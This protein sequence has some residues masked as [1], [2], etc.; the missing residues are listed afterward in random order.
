MIEQMI[1]QEIKNLL[2]EGYVMNHENFQFRQ[3]V[4]NT[5]VNLYNYESFSGDYDVN[6]TD[7]NVFVK[8]NIKFWLNE[9]GVENFIVEV[10][11]VEGMYHI[12]MYDKQSDKMVQET[13]KDIN[14]VKSPWKFLVA[15]ATLTKGGSLYVNDLMFDFAKGECQVTFA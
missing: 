10:T 6:I 13:E 12:E 1:E 4:D 2:K 11:G 8:W 5:N 3:N 15:E 7:S 14:E 9:S